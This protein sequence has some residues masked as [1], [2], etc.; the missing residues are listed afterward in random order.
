M[1]V[2]NTKLRSYDSNCAN[3]CLNDLID[4]SFLKI[5][6]GMVSVLD[7][8]VKNVTDAFKK[9]GLWDNTVMIFSTGKNF[10]QFFPSILYS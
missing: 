8:A 1:Q 3:F 6:S 10:A 5:F 2:N 9:Y 7:E 4:Q